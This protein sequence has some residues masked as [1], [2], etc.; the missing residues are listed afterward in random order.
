MSPSTTAQ[1]TLW[2]SVTGTR[3]TALRLQLERFLFVSRANAVPETKTD[4]LVGDAANRSAGRRPTSRAIKVV[5]KHHCHRNGGVGSHWIGLPTSFI[6][7]Y[8]SSGRVFWRLLSG[9][10][11]GSLCRLFPVSRLVPRHER[12]SSTSPLFVFFPAL[13]SLSRH[14]EQHMPMSPSSSSASMAESAWRSPSNESSHTCH[15]PPLFLSSA[16]CLCAGQA[17]Q[18]KKKM[19]MVSYES[20]NAPSCKVEVESQEKTQTLNNNRPCACS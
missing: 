15:S 7:A 5:G 13:L 16:Q 3:R 8:H 18:K 12:F 9:P 6:H 11:G 17:T 14:W 4:Q 19:T 10:F 1:E 20:K 2:S